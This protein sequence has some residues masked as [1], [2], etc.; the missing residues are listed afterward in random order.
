MGSIFGGGGDAAPPPTYQTPPQAGTPVDPQIL[1]A[2]TWRGQAGMPYLS[3][4]WRTMDFLHGL[5][6]Q[7][8][9][10]MQTPQFNPGSGQSQFNPGYGGGY[11]QGWDPGVYAQGSQTPSGRDI[12][13]LVFGGAN[14]GAS[15][16]PPGASSGAGGAVQP[17]GAQ[18]GIGDAPRPSSQPLQGN[19]PQQTNPQGT[20]T[21][22]DAGN[23]RNYNY[24]PDSRFANAINA[25]SGPQFSH[26]APDVVQGLQ[27][28]AARNII[29]VQQ[30]QNMYQGQTGPGNGYGSPYQLA[31][32]SS[33]PFGPQYGRAF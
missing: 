25:F 33:N 29:Q 17:K 23:N 14:S 28:A 32:Y 5:G 3:S 11:T 18:S 1:A 9:G 21:Y 4:P 30:L 15:N 26:V 16:G 19:L 20:Q 2:A 6:G 8:I 22:H 12:F 27:D 24:A 10:A 7:G 31:G 13:N